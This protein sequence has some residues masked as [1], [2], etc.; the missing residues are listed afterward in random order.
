MQFS[1]T[2]LSSNLIWGVSTY[3]HYKSVRLEVVKFSKF[4][5]P[6]LPL[7]LKGG[8]GEESEEDSASEAFINGFFKVTVFTPIYQPLKTIR[9]LIQCGYEPISPYCTTGRGF[10]D[11]L[12]DRPDSTYTYLPGAIGY[13][14]GLF[15]HYGWGCF[16]AGMGASMLETL[17]DS[18][19]EAFWTQLVDAFLNYIFS[20]EKKEERY[21]YFNSKKVA[22]AGFKGSILNFITMLHSYPLFVV[23]NI[24]IL[25]CIKGEPSAWIWTIM[26]EIWNEAGLRG[27]FSGFLAILVY[28]L[29]NVWCEEVV[30][31]VLRLMMQRLN[32]NHTNDTYMNTNY[33]LI[34]W[35]ISSFTYPLF[36]IGNVMS[37][38]KCSA[39]YLNNK[40]TYFPVFPSWT[41][42]FK[43]MYNAGIWFR[44]SSVLQRRLLYTESK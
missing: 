11:F 36:L 28:R 34:H 7:P 44:G 2:F 6:S 42:C 9:F 20:F 43:H 8:S 40:L 19:T 24:C 23:G 3:P 18:L 16:S 12:M 17:I 25:R 38:N 15:R 27:F 13:S 32:E 29:I 31:E 26:R 22:K 30:V 10:F 5:R 33:G 41:A 35:I 14:R 4:I 39:R 21:P 1:S 37:V